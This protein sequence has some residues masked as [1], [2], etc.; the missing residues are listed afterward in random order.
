[1]WRPTSTCTIEACLP[2]PGTVPRASTATVAGR[3]V[4]ALGVLL[5]A[6]V[7]LALLPRHRVPAAARRAAR[8]LLGALGIR[9][10]VTGRLVTRRALVVANHVS[11]LD[12]V[13]L[14]A[15]LPVRMLAKND[16]RSWPMI[17][18]IA[19]AMDTVFIDRDRPRELPHTVGAVAGVLAGGGVVAAFP[20]GTTWCGRKGGPLRPAVFQAAIGA[21]ATIAPVRIGFALADGSPTT[22]AAFIGADSLAASLRRVITT[23]GLVVTLRA[24]PPIHPGPDS[25]RGVTR[26]AVAAVVQAVIRP[27]ATGPAPV[28]IA[29]SSSRVQ[30]VA[31]GW[32]QS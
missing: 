11:W 30:P 26:R 2:R 7:V 8:A 1:M 32:R 17:G 13:V 10:K 28:H 5:A 14:M 20:E 29:G 25:G 4:A 16:V 6:T 23:R 18:R 19:V 9:H 12:I 27:D 24:H 15:H 31:V 21:G 22:V 3:T